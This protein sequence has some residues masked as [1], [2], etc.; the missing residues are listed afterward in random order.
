[1]ATPN[2]LPRELAPG[3]WWLGEC[4][5]QP[6][7]GTMLHSSNS[8]FVVCGEDSS[9]I[10]EGG[11]PKDLVVI[12]RQ[13][14]G[15]MERGIPEV[16][17]VFTTHQETPHCS[18]IGRMLQRFPEALA[19]GPVA[20]FH[21][22]FPQYEDRFMP[23]EI[24]ESVDLGGSEFVAVEAVIR[25]LLYTRWGYDTSRRALFPGDGFAYNHYH[26]DEQCGAVAE[27]VPELD[28]EDMTAMFAEF[29]LYW[30]QF[31]DL[32]PYIARLDDLIG[33]LGVELVAPTHGLP[34]SDLAATLPRVREGLRLGSAKG[35]PPPDGEA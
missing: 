21:L 28:I 30:T 3:I 6:H 14:D 24:G 4:L 2:P 11:H 23:L 10:V 19:C 33:E 29:A 17:Y 1:V 31:V 9:L 32:E 35:A 7:G 16:R 8:V 25:D 20:D 13:I 18:G 5:L 27:E 34:I 26:T 12:E 22:V 15:L